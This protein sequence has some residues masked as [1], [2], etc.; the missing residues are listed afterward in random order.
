MKARTLYVFTRQSQY[1]WDLLTED[2]ALGEPMWA[3][4]GGARLPAAKRGAPGEVPGGAEHLM[5]K[6]AATTG[7]WILAGWPPLF[8]AGGRRR[9]GAWVGLSVYFCIP[10]RSKIVCP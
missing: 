2:P 10:G 4:A 3:A 5:A 6:S 7:S 8:R 9:A 1:E